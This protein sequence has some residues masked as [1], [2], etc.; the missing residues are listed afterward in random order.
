MTQ[1]NFDLSPTLF[2]NGTNQA[3]VNSG[4]YFEFATRGGSIASSV[5]AG[6]LINDVAVDP[7]TGDAY[8]TD[9]YNCRE[10]WEKV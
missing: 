2:P 5:P 9:S 7:D 4:Q 8:F 10:F 3:A 6:M 1:F